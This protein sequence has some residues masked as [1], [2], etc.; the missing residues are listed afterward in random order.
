MGW[1]G[2][3]RLTARLAN[4]GSLRST[5]SLTAR[6]PGGM[7]MEGRPPKVSVRG[8]GGVD[9]AAAGAECDAGGADGERVDAEFVGE[10]DADG[11][12]AEGDVDDLAD[13]WCRRR[14]R[15]AVG[16]CDWRGDGRGGPGADPVVGLAAAK[17]TWTEA[18][19]RAKEQQEERE[20]RRWMFVMA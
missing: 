16:R 15:L 5:G 19:E 14:R 18:E 12:S 10:D 6:A 7:V 17:A 8:G 2:T 11:G 3:K 20:A 1:A 13:R 4:G 9:V